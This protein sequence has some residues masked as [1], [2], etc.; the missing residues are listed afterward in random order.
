MFK[1]VIVGTIAAFAAATINHPVNKEIVEDIKQ[2]T[3]QWVPMEPEENPLAQ[4]S[5]NHILG[6]L[7][8][9]ISEPANFPG[10][11]LVDN[12]PDNFDSRTQWGSC[13]HP[14]RDQA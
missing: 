11:A 5:T 3:S 10:P 13:V 12:L 4:Y 1:L 2:K 14:I 8:T 6:L 7:G 9:K